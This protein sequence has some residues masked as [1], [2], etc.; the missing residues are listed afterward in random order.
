MKKNIGLLI[1]TSLLS[2]MLF[3]C[4][5][6][7]MVSLDEAVTASWAQVQNQYQRRLDLIPN[8]VSTVKG[9][10]QHDQR[11]DAGYAQLQ[12]L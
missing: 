11:Q 7:K 3:S 10:A 6:N 1:A 12:I 4:T 5:Y 2:M 8:L 9:Y